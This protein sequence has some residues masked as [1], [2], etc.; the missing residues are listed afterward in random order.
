MAEV[1]TNQVAGVSPRSPVAASR[2]RKSAALKCQ[3][4]CTVSPD[5]IPCD[6]PFCILNQGGT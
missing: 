5:E 3:C 2:L 1:K 6:T 4:G